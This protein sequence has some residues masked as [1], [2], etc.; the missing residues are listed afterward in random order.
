MQEQPRDSSRNYTSHKEESKSMAEITVQYWD[1]TQDL[2]H[3]SLS[4]VGEIA[5]SQE[6]KD[7]QDLCVMLKLYQDN[8]PGTV[9]YCFG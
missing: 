4:R 2:P 3:S 8:D 6:H 1:F 5:L 9:L 7:I